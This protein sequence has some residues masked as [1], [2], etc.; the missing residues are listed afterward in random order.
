VI[1]ATTSTYAYD[2]DGLRDS[3]TVGENAVSY[4]WDVNAGLPVVLQ[5][6][7]GNSYVYGLDLISATDNSSVQTY[8]LSDGLGSTTELA[9]DEGTVTGMYAYDVFGPVRTHTGATTEWSYTGEQNDPSGLE[10]LRARYY[11]PALGRFLSRDP[12]PFVQRYAYVGNSPLRFTDPYGLGCPKGT[13]WFC[14][15]VEGAW[16]GIK[17]G[18]Q[19]LG[20]DYHWLALVEVG[21]AAA[22]VA[23]VE[24]VTA[25]TAT[26]FVAGLGGGMIAGGLGVGASATA[27][28]IA[29][30][31]KGCKE[32]SKMSCAE[33]GVTAV[34][35]PFS[36]L[37]GGRNMVIGLIGPVTS[38]AGDV[39]SSLRGAQGPQQQQSQMC[40]PPKE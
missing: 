5:D 21:G 9:D 15:T 17:G 3:Q 33:A 31:T 39:M 7:D 2:G 30:R 20:E 19:W 18:A 23:G 10:Y 25:G 1:G 26:P 34:T 40:K 4:T 13:G 11:D 37:P 24:I 8:F 14:D 6:S 12:I 16:G 35:A 22:C 27:V 32:G 38:T 29:L 36:Y 28:D